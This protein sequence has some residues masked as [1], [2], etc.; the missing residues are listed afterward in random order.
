[1]IDASDNQEKK[2][3][4]GSDYPLTVTD[5]LKLWDAGELL[6]S[7]EMGGLGPAYEQAIQVGV[8][9]LCRRIYPLPVMEDEKLNEYL[10]DKVHEVIKASKGGL[11]GLSGAQA[12]AIKSLSYH[13]CHRG[14]RV[15]LLDY[16]ESDKERLTM[17]SK[18]WPRML[19]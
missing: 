2:P 1:M 10:D 14:W 13:L 7:I 6:W 3:A 4:P 16:R 12:S 9:E 8:I 18:Q 11:Q 15:V 19:E 5:A 17:I